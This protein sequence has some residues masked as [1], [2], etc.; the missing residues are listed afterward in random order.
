M[1]ED[2]FDE[3][4]AGSLANRS[5]LREIS[6]AHNALH[7][8]L[9]RF[10]NAAQ[11]LQ[12]SPRL[13]VHELTKGAIGVSMHSLSVCE[14]AATV[15]EGILVLEEKIKGEPPCPRAFRLS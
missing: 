4:V 12:L 10:G 9:G 1:Q 7:T 2:F 15:I 5:K 3:A 6:H 13:Q 8:L 11:V 14:A